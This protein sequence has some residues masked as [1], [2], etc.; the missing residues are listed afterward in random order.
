[1]SD[2]TTPDLSTVSYIAHLDVEFLDGQPP[3]GEPDRIPDV[4]ADAI[5][6]IGEIKVDGDRWINIDVKAIDVASADPDHE[7]TKAF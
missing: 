5:N 1:M 2:T 7:D 3:A 4:L 6:T